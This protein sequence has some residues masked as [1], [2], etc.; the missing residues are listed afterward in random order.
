MKVLSILL[1]IFV[2]VNCQERFV[3][4]VLQM[5]PTTNATTFRCVGTVFKPNYIVLP[6]SC[7][8]V[9][10]NMALAVEVQMGSE[11]S[12]SKF[13]V[14][15]LVLFDFPSFLVPAANTIIHPEFDGSTAPLSRSNNIAVIRVATSSHLISCQT[16]SK[17]LLP[18]QIEEALNSTVIHPRNLGMLPTNET[19]HLHGWGGADLNSRQV[20]INVY[21]PEFCDINFPQV[22]CTTFG[23]IAD[24]TCTALLGS[25]L[26]CTD[27]DDIAGFVITSEETCATQGRQFVLQYHSIGGFNEW[28][29][30]VSGAETYAKVSSIL[31]IL[32]AALI[33]V[34]N[35]M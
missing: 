4:R 32:S 6:A 9:G 5:N 28:I 14:K 11:S 25:P 24:D 29:H 22:F 34:K 23:S 12:L 33:S 31:L 3:V 15:A 13:A 10:A 2:A 18:L 19:C 17:L 20:A 30:E 27:H 8:T 7:A 21:S 1:A 35:M 16:S 26:T